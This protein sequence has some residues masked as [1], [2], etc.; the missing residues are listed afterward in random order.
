MTPG[1][2]R[3]S[4]YQSGAAR[5][6]RGVRVPGGLRRRAVRRVRVDARAPAARARRRVRAVRLQRTR[7]LRRG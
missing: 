7:R 4:G 6:A 3:D 1:P 2:S 5:S